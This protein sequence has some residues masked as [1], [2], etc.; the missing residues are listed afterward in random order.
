LVPYRSN[1]KSHADADVAAST[2]YAKPIKIYPLSQASNPP[3]TVFTDVKDVL[4]DSTIHFDESFAGAENGRGVRGE[5]EK[6]PLIA[7]GT[8]DPYRPQ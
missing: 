6:Y 8:P 1:M 2:A 5:H 4:F 3:A 7:M